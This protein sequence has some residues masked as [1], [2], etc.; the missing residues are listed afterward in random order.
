MVKLKEA[1]K[2]KISEKNIPSSYDIIGSIAAFSKLPKEKKKQKSIANRLLE[3][4]KNIKTVL[5][6]V[7]EFSGKYRLPRYKIIAGKKTK[8]TI[9]RENNC[10]F[11]LDLEKCYFSSRLS[12]ERLRIAKQVKF[13]E[14]ILVMFSGVG[15]FPLVI[16]KNSKAKEIYGIEMN[17]I[18]HQYAV[19]NLFLNK[20]NNIKLIKGDVKKVIPKLNQKFDRILMPLPKDADTFL[21]SAL[22][23]AKKNTVIHFYDFEKE[24]EFDKAINKINK[25]MKKNKKTIKILTVAKCG[26]Y[27]PRISR[28]C[29]DF[30]IL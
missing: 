6:K 21:E 1:L 26:E 17:P 14:T 13:N 20:I 15:I 24:G 23:V 28:I 22:K 27:G 30:K 5:F 7:R 12:N 29:V 16:S 2:N 19:E 25:I 3:L 9:Y 18:A 11:K 4:N 10:I 8:E